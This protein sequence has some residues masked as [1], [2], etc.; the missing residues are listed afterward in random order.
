MGGSLPVIDFAEWQGEPPDR[1]FLWGS[2]L[3]LLQTTMLTGP[4][5]VGK[6]LLTQQLLTCIALGIPFLGL[7]TRQANCLYVTCEDDRDELWR[8]QYSICKRLGYELEDLAGRLHLVS[9][10]GETDTALGTFKDTGQI[11][12]SSRWRELEATVLERNVQLFAFDN[13]TDAMAGDLNDIH[14]VAEF[15]NLLTGLAIRIKGG[16]LILHHPNKAGED[17]LGSIAWHNKV[18]SRLIMKKGE[19]PGDHDQRTLSNPKANYGPSGSDIAFRWYAGAFVTD[20]EVPDTYFA[21]LAAS[22]EAAADNALFLA[23]LR[24]RTKEH[25]TVSA[26]PS[27]TYAPSEFA[28][29][30]ESKGIGRD[31]LKL[32]MDRLF[33]IGAIEIGDLPWQR[34]DRHQAKGLRETAGNA[35]GNAGNAPG[36]LRHE[37]AGNAGNAPASSSQVIEKYAGNV[38]ATCGS[39]TPPPYGGRGEGP[40]DGASPSPDEGERYSG[41]D[42]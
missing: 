11:E 26:S 25:R 37:R 38:R 29:M 34:L 35:A 5:G 33:S 24:Q 8:R 15:V 14:Q 9:L 4:G 23:C 28:D 41:F 16:A 31:R 19:T 12:P 22:A 40:L 10:C 17:W 3:P 1:G 7:E 18:R 36:D 20:E 6:S 27:R 13:A 39:N 21:E 30:R 32:A 2:L 42:D